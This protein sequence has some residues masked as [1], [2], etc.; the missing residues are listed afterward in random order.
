MIEAW[1]PTI[2]RARAGGGMLRRR[3]DLYRFVHPEG[4]GALSALDERGS[5]VRLLGAT[6]IA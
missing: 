4:C 3:D 6:T 1:R 5:K 2:P